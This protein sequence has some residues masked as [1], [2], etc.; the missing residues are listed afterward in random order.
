MHA[1]GV[2]HQ[3]VQQPELGR[4]EVHRL[5]VAGDAM[6]GRV[7]LQ[8]AVLHHVVRH[9][10]RAPAQHGLDARIQ[11]ARRERLG[12]VIVGASLQTLQL[13][14]L[15]GA[16]GQHDDRDRAGALVGAQSSRELDA[17]KSG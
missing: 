7:E 3:K 11:F 5:A 1:L 2:R 6:A 17:R 16:G 8:T 12:D 4:P 14:L 9:L 13:V 15:V 10:R